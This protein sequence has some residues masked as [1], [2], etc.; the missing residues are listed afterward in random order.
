MTNE[1]KLTAY[2]NELD[3]HTLRN[4]ARRIGVYSPTTKIKTELIDGISDIVFKRTEAV[5]P[6]KR[7]APVKDRDVD[8]S[9]LD[10][11]WS[12]STDY[13]YTP[14]EARKLSMRFASSESV[15]EGATFGGILL[16]A[17]EPLL[18]GK[19]EKLPF[20]ITFIQ[21]LGLREGDFIVCKIK[22]TGDDL[23]VKEI[24]SVNLRIRSKKWDRIRFDSYE[25]AYPSELYPLPL[26]SETMRAIDFFAPIGYGQ[27]VECRFFHKTDRCSFFV[28]LLS[29]V[30][31]SDHVLFLHAGMSKEETNELTEAFQSAEH[32]FVDP[33][34][35]AEENLLTLHMVQ[36]RVKRISEERE[37]V[38]LVLNSLGGI[39]RISPSECYKLFA[40]ARHI[41]CGDVTVFGIT[42]KE[43][44]QNDELS[45][46]ANCVL[47]FAQTAQAKLDPMRSYTKRE[48]KFCSLK[49]VK[50]AERVREDFNLMKK[51][52]NSTS[53]AVFEEENS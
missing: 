2:L 8:F 11:I 17:D 36:E 38:F 49:K 33:S 24:L 42:S 31:S 35:D 39:Y 7:G 10:R 18:V 48:E 45:S 37:N 1:E 44:I 5:V 3:I 46:L 20:P 13:S 21:E 43:E 15:Y 40:L 16:F 51:W 6:S 27:R 50:L 19:R 41:E 12:F 25:S 22:N 14:T 26:K 34:M 32:Y 28:D 30:S 53:N 4:V 9:I 52:E 47:D 29:S 23:A